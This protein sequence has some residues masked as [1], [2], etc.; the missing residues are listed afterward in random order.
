MAAM[1][2]G[3]IMGRNKPL[4]KPLSHRCPRSQ[5]GMH[6]VVRVHH[7]EHWAG[8]FCTMCQRR[9]ASWPRDF[10]PSDVTLEER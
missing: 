9:L 10:T 7:G 4:H 6:N 3:R 1:K 5:S 8:Y 2:G